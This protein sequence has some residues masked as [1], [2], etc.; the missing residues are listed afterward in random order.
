VREGADDDTPSHPLDFSRVSDAVAEV[1]VPP[2]TLTL[3]RDTPRPRDTYLGVEDTS[4]A[5]I[6]VGGPVTTNF[7]LVPPPVPPPQRSWPLVVRPDYAL[8]P[9]PQPRLVTVQG[10]QAELRVSTPVAPR[11]L[12]TVEPQA[13][14]SKTPL[15]MAPW[16]VTSPLTGQM[17]SFLLACL[18]GN[19]PRWCVEQLLPAVPAHLAAAAI[20]VQRASDGDDGNQPPLVV[21]ASHTSPSAPA[22]TADNSLPA[23][24]PPSTAAASLEQQLGGS[25]SLSSDEDSLSGQQPLPAEA[26]AAIAD[27]AEP[28]PQ[29]QLT[30][31]TSTASTGASWADMASEE[32][33]DEPLSWSQLVAATSMSDSAWADISSDEEEE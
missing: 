5:F 18:G 21:A 22:P 6:L 33:E 10:L 29:E 2:R 19:L 25:S 3:I 15:R 27:D 17:P 24:Q 4:R 12:M 23:D 1:V 8:V 28:L 9:V 26:A 31:S 20:G 30:R 14:P 32:D 13:L 16:L 11:E 7:V